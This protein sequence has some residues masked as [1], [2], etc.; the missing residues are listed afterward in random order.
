VISLIIKQASSILIW[1]YRW[2]P[3]SDSTLMNIEEDRFEM[4]C[5][6]CDIA[7][8][9]AGVVISDNDGAAI[10]IFRKPSEAT[11]GSLI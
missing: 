1:G 8:T 2:Y 6:T 7:I 3:D 10:D 4:I 9:L 11:S 5:P